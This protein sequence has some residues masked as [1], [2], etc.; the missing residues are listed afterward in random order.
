MPPGKVLQPVLKM[1]VDE[2]FL[3]WLSESSTQA[4]LR[5]CLR[6]IQMPA[7]AERGAG[8][9]ELPGPRLAAAAPDPAWR[10]RECE[11]PGAPGPTPAPTT[12]P[13]GAAS[14]ARSGPPVRGPRRS[15]GTRVS[16]RALQDPVDCS[17]SEYRLVSPHRKA[18]WS[19]DRG[20]AE[21]VDQSRTTNTLKMSRF[22]PTSSGCAVCLRLIIFHQ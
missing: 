20:C 8:D 3:C 5:D 19:F 4:M 1:K 18:C 9:A 10:P 17:P 13:V 6:R 16:C 15:G 14:S 2:L 22:A 7:R 21:S 12:L 11:G